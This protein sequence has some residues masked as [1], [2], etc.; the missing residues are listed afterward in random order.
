M[1]PFLEVQRAH[2]LLHAQVTGEAPRV[3]DA[4]DRLHVKAA[5]DALCWVLEHAHNAAF[6]NNLAAIEKELAE[7]GYV[8]RGPD[9]AEPVTAEGLAK[10]LDDLLHQVGFGSSGLVKLPWDRIGPDVQH[11]Y[12]ERCRL[13]LESF[14]VTRKGPPL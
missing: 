2:D 8:L 13:F 1:M 7:R 12:V 9:V 6:R 4:D 14:D 3:I 11:L 5:L 10:L